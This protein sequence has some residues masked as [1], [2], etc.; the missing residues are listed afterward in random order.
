M[1]TFSKQK[2]YLFKCDCHGPHFMSITWWEDDK[3]AYDGYFTLEGAFG[4]G[5]HAW[6]H[7]LQEAWQLIRSGH[8]DT[9]VE[10]H[11][12]DSNKAR[13][14]AEA[15]TEFADTRDALKKEQEEN[16]EEPK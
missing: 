8:A 2:E 13:R 9:W 15:L 7:R 12:D 5:K 4:S 1:M 10:I 11:L 14:I 3:D 6:L 16:E